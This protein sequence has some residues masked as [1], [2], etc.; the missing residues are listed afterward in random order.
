MQPLAYIA[1]IE[2]A[3]PG[4]F[5]V[6]FPDVPEA[7]TQGDDLREARG[8]ARDALA[9]ALE[10]YLE[11]GRDFPERAELD[12]DGGKPGVELFD[13]AVEPALAARALL[14]RQMKVQGLSKVGLAQR[15]NRDEKAV[16]RILSGR[17][18]SLDLTLEA[19]RA[20]GVRPALAA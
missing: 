5:L 8:N 15:M 1:F 2:E 18:A 3:E 17:G 13:V 10:G 20:V 14:T 9:A 16:R 19:L 11:A 6:T 12:P 4:A 7:I